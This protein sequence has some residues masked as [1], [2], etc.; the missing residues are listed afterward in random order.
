MIQDIVSDPSIVICPAD[1]GKAIVIEDRDTYL[2]KMQQQI[3]DG[4]Y[5]LEKRK[6]KTLLD[7][8]HKKLIK[9]LKIMDID[10]DDFKEKKESIWCQSD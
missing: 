10:L 8:L 3:K 1:K 4:D 6:E 2:S 7:K 5:I 9:Q